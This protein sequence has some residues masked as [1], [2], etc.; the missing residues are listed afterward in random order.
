LKKENDYNKL[1]RE[2]AKVA[3]NLLLVYDKPDK[4]ARVPFGIFD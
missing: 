2:A 1:T 3:Q 4:R